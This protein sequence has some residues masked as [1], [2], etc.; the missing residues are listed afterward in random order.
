MFRNLFVLKDISKFPIWCAVASVSLLCFSCD[1]FC[2]ESN[3]TAIVVNFYSSDDGTPLTVNNPKIK[4]IGND[5]VLYS[6]GSF[7]QVLL[8]VN[9]AAD[10]MS[11]SIE[12]DE[13][14]ADVIIFNYTRHNGFISSEC[15]CVTFAE[16][17]SVEIQNESEEIENT[18]KQ[19]TVTN[20]SVNTVSYRRGVVNAENIRIYY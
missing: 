7:S 17:Q 9:P 5:S 2:E 20:N 11:F 10:M 1:E 14:P 3:R 15:G 6:A 4:G 16:I 13:L 18:I 12:R 8:P 19:I